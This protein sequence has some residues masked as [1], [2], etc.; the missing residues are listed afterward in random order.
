MVNT[1]F[2]FP[3]QWETK[4]AFEH[5]LAVPDIAQ[6]RTSPLP[7]W[8]LKHKFDC[9]LRCFSVREFRFH[10]HIQVAV[11]V[12]FCMADVEVK[13]ISRSGVGNVDCESYWSSRFPHIVFDGN[14]VFKHARLITAAHYENRKQT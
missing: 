8:I 7:I 12:A 1:E 6:S 5:D 14:V 9:V 11:L 4:V 3:F 2:V 13:V 10:K